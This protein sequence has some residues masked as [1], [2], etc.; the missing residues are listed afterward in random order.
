MLQLLLDYIAV[1]CTLMPS[2]VT[3]RVVW[4]IQS[5]SYVCV[6]HQTDIKLTQLNHTYVD[7]LL[8]QDNDVMHVFRAYTFDADDHSFDFLMLRSDWTRFQTQ[9]MWGLLTTFARPSCVE[10]NITKTYQKTSGLAATSTTKKQGDAEVGTRRRRL[11]RFCLSLCLHHYHHHHR[12]CLL[13]DFHSFY[14]LRYT[15][16]CGLVCMFLL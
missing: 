14:S 9:L 8:F 11:C 7:V 4:S 2:I 12:R 6:L 16:S 1:L 15:N 3:D 10:G 5:F 13:F